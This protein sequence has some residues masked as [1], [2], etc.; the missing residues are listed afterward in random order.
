MADQ[1]AP[2]KTYRGNCHCKAHVYEINLPEIKSVGA[3][4]CSS[5][6]KK[7]IL[8]NYSKYSDLTWAKGDESSLADYTFGKK[9]MHYKF[10][11]TCGVTLYCVGYFEPPKPGENKEPVFALNV[12]AIQ[13]LDVWSLDTMAMDGASFGA[14]FEPAK[15]TGKLPEAELEGSSPFYGSCHC[16]AIKIAM[17]SPPLDETYDDRVIECNCSICGRYGTT[18]VYPRKEFVAVEGEENLTYYKMGRGLFDKGFC[19]TCAVPIENR[20][21]KI[22]EEQRAALPEGGRFW[23]DRGLLHRSLNAKILDGVD[24]AK[25][26]KERIDGWK[27]IL[28]PYENP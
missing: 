25:L 8:W 28:P 2:T 6:T 20:T 10:C 17:K 19:K 13:D 24:L 21:A 14:P 4:N 7:G 16:G 15:F 9:G 1:A 27:N 26:K 11:P 12:R 3:C 22:S 23:Y 18:W 5:C